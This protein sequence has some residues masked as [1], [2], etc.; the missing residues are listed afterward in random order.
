M[1]DGIHILDDSFEKI[2][3]APNFKQFPGFPLFCTGQP[4]EEA[5]E[6][7]INIKQEK[8]FKRSFG[9]S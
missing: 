5:I 8:R 3:G 9:L 4:A 6:E 7:I 2:E 1:F